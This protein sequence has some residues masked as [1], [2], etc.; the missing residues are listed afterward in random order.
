[1]T[2]GWMVGQFEP[3]VYQKDYELGFKYYQQGD[4]EQSHCH[5]KSEEVTII[6]L[7]SV[8]MNDN[9]YQEGDIVVQEQGE[10]TDFECLS[11]RAITAV[12]RPDG[13]FPQ[14]KYVRDNSTA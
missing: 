9:I 12:Y 2:R 10:Y 11:E 6:L 14:D 4:Y 5:L 1:M 3:H 13:S 7:G 8:K